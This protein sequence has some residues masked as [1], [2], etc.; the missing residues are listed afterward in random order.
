MCYAFLSITLVHG[1]T[2]IVSQ[3][4]KLGILVDKHW[5]DENI[6]LKKKEIVKLYCVLFNNERQNFCI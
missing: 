6:A 1:N 2:F 3:R 5:K 4:V